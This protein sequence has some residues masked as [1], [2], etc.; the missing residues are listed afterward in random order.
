MLEVAAEQFA[1]RPYRAVS[2]D[3][4]AQRAGVT[5]PM[6][7]S[8]FGSKEGLYAGCV[9]RLVPRLL[10]ALDEAARPQATAEAR[11][12][13]GIL[14]QLRFIESHP[15]EWRAF[16]RAPLTVGGPSVTA[17]LDGRRRLI[18]LL[19]DLIASSVEQSGSPLPPRQEIEAQAAAFQ[20]SVER[21]TDWWEDH[22]Q[23]T[24]EAVALRI[25]NFAWQGFGNLIEGR[26]WAP[27]GG[28]PA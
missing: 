13:E 16:V 17:L 9:E 27:P 18:S 23:E 5:K 20:G 19:A 21:M 10:K 3:D 7:Y 11:V 25:M 2:M 28:E 24:V 22:P 26:F 4:L 15:D 8:Y 1:K 14:A 6:L 12:W